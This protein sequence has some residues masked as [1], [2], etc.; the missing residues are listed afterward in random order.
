MGGRL[1]VRGIG[2]LAACALALAACSSSSKTGA[3]VDSTVAQKATATA[4]GVSADTIRVGITYP[5][6]EAL[7]KTG[8]LTVDNGPYDPIIRA[9]VDDVNASGGINGRK[10]QAF[11]GKYSVL[12]VDSQLAL[13]TKLTE[14]NKVFAVLGGFVGENNLCVS[15][16]H[17]TPLVSGYGSGYN[18]VALK[19]ARAPW[20]T[21]NASDDRALKALVQILHQQGS[22]KDK[23]IAVYAQQTSSKSLVD[24]T[25]NALKDAG[26]QVTDTAIMGISPTDTQAFTAQDKVIA[27]RFK[28]EGVNVMFLVDSTPTA[29]NW[30]AVGFHP[31]VYVP[32]TDLVTPGAYTNPFHKFPII[33]GLSGSADPDAG[34]N[35]PAMKKCR[36]AYTKA[37]GKVVK[38]LADE[39]ADGESSGN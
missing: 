32:Q 39:T 34:Y 27:Q 11:I 33:A 22:L 30:D 15:Q 10:L 16:Q 17:A 21:W 7:A 19:K 6:L 37:T 23:K 20:S 13:C 31:E 14:D 25:V 8:L 2:L 1:G 36:E 18:G 24:I 28:D 29:A 3:T 5:D 38:T 4:K 12:S 26:Y 9:I 35:T